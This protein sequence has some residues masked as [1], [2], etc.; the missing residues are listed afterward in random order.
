VS[1][2]HKFVCLDV[3]IVK[4][5]NETDHILISD[6]LAA[7]IRKDGAKAGRLM[8]DDSDKRMEASHGRSVHQQEYIDKIDALTVRACGPGYLM[9]HL[10][11]YISFICD[12][13]A[14]H[15]VML[16]QSLISAALAVKVQEGIALALDPTVQIW[17]IAVP[18]ILEG[19]RRRGQVGKRASEMMGLDRLFTWITGTETEVTASTETEKS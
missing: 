8:M 18:I 9:E 2:D 14:T 4:E 10:G 5:F 3:G 6:V 7:F 17:K 11:V 1:P 15:H 13:A 19:E 16:N 12:C